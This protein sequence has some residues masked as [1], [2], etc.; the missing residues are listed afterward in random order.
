MGAIDQ[1]QLLWQGRNALTEV[2]KEMHGRKCKRQQSTNQTKKENAAETSA[3][4][5]R[6]QSETF[7]TKTTPVERE[8]C[9]WNFNQKG[10]GGGNDKKN[11]WGGSWKSH[12]P[13]PQKNKKSSWRW[14][15]RGRPP[16]RTMRRFN[17][18]H[19]TRRRYFV[20]MIFEKADSINRKN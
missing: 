6:G 13:A 5:D 17:I 9:V 12:S 18:T 7:V 1:E 3:K 8:T 20:S 14:F 11:K 15:S 2:K 16:E 4:S 10:T 19:Q